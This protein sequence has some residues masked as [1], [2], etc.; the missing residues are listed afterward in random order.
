MIFPDPPGKFSLFGR[1]NFIELTGF[2]GGSLNG[3]HNKD[4]KPTA[5]QTLVDGSGVRGGLG[6]APSGLWLAQFLRANPL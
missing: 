2:R 5:A 6:P 1:K 3:L 4:R